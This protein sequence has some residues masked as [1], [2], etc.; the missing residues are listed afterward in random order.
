MYTATRNVILADT[1]T[2]PKNA[3]QETSSTD[4]GRSRCQRCRT[5]DACARTSLREAVLVVQLE[6]SICSLSSNALQKVGMCRDLASNVTRARFHAPPFGLRNSR[7]R[8]AAAL[9]TGRS[10][11]PGEGSTLPRPAGRI[12]S[13]CR[14]QPRLGL[15]G[16]CWN[17]PGRRA[18]GAGL[19][20]PPPPPPPRGI[21]GTIGPRAVAGGA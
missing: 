19:S 18:G 1:W 15:R 5:S 6:A 20:I 13:P 14:A 9:G 2:R 3:S 12:S 7:M 8:L 10:R 4:D 17:P 21:A 11:S 16:S